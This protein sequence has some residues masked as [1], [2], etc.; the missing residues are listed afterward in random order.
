M[1]KWYEGLGGGN[2]VSLKLGETAEIEVKEIVKIEDKPD[3]DPKKKDG[4]VQGFHYDFLTTD[5][6]TLSISSF[7][8]QSAMV[9]AKV[10][11][12][13][14]LKIAHPDKGIYIVEKIS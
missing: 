13:D 9:N 7:A 12:G 1:E 6:K 4:S 10:D 3:F 8:L 14:K 5:G 11:A 2:F